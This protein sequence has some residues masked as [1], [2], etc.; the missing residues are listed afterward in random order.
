M[1]RSQVI[2]AYS[3]M[4]GFGARRMVDITDQIMPRIA[5]PIAAAP[6]HRTASAS[7]TERALAATLAQARAEASERRAVASY[8]PSYSA[9]PAQS[10]ERIRAEAQLCEAGTTWA[11]ALATVRRMN[12]ACRDPEAAMLRSLGAE[13][14]KS[15]QKYIAGLGLS[16]AQ[17][18]ANAA[19]KGAR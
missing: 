7:E 5:A 9:P 1:H 16:E 11:S 4:Q 14:S 19:K 10:A 3:T 8:S 6:I 2:A 18:F 12:P 17:F 13:L 15:D